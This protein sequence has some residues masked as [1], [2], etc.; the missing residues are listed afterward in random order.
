[1][2]VW[3]R[4]PK[5]CER[6]GRKEEGWVGRALA[7]LKK[8]QP[9]SPV[10]RPLHPTAG[11]PEQTSRSIQQSREGPDP[12]RSAGCRGCVTGLPPASPLAVFHAHHPSSRHP[13]LLEVGV[14]QLQCLSFQNHTPFQFCLLEMTPR[15]PWVEFERCPK[16]SSH[17]FIDSFVAGSQPDK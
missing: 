16:T 6:R 4:F 14:E 10:R 1:M 9:R 15:A 12:R 8:S 7:Q 3:H 17:T 13:D 2:R 11:V 5:I